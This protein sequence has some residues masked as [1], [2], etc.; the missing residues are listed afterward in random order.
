MLF[1]LCMLVWMMTHVATLIGHMH[2]RI[3]VVTLV[4]TIGCYPPCIT[5]KNGLTKVQVSALT[6][7]VIISDCS[8]MLVKFMSNGDDAPSKNS[9]MKVLSSTQTPKE[10]S[11]N[12]KGRA[13]W[14]QSKSH[15]FSC[16][17]F[18][19]NS[20]YTSYGWFWRIFYFIFFR[21][22]FM[23]HMAGLEMSVSLINLKRV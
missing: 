15:E 10:E 23:P 7:L 17:V 9:R 6:I 19:C 21:I 22:I 1:T 18:A 2:V 13:T 8:Q 11:P 14:F 4:S 16:I 3:E 12:S 20:L 5:L